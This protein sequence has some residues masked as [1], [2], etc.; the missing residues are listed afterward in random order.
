MSKRRQSE[1][2]V[3]G[4]IEPPSPPPIQ[5]VE[6]SRCPACGS[7]ERN[8]YHHTR[9]LDYCGTTPDG[10]NYSRVV[11]RNVTCKNCGKARIDKSYEGTW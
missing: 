2:E 3:A 7:T 6:P 10:R 8:G 9:T 4:K 5:V 1:N 11:W